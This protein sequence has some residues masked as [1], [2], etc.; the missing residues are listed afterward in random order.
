MYFTK[1]KDYLLSN[2]QFNILLN[3]LADLRKTLELA[4]CIN[5]HQLAY[6]FDI[7]IKIITINAN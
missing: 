5:L 3:S 1:L 4:S 6:D 7:Y 2:I